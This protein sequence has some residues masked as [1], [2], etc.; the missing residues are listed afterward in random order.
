MSRSIM[1]YQHSE[2]LDETFTFLFI[3][4]IRD[5][6]KQSAHNMLHAVALAV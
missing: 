5:D 2:Y 1:S 3:A 6:T 4:R